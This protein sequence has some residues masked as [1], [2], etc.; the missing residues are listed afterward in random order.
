MAADRQIQVRQ[1]HMTLVWGRVM[2]D[3][4]Y[5]CVFAPGN[6]L[7]FPQRTSWRLV[8]QEREVI[9]CGGSQRRSA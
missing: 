7:G 2:S 1:A 8:Q 9:L 3:P 6:H 5:T 4:G